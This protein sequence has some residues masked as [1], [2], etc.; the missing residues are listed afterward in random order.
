MA[1][2]CVKSFIVDLFE[3]MFESKEGAKHKDVLFSTATV[4]KAFSINSLV[5]PIALFIQHYSFVTH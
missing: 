5:D 3:I 2:P 4:K 1:E